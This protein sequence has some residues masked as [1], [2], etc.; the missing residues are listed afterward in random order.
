MLTINKEPRKI[1]YW[2]QGGTLSPRL[3][4]RLRYLTPSLAQSNRKT[5]YPQGTETG[6]KIDGL[7]FM[8]Q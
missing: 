6:S 8:G 5:G 7:Q 2:I 4:K 1:I 3:R